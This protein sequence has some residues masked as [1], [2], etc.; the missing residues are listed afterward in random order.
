MAKYGYNGVTAAIQMSTEVDQPAHL[1]ALTD[2][3]FLLFT[4]IASTDN[5]FKRIKSLTAHCL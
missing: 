1:A 3:R 4:V 5:G 2:I